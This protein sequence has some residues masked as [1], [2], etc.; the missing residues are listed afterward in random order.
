[1]ASGLGAGLVSLRIKQYERGITIGRHSPR[2]EP[3]H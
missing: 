3:I 1:M 2:G